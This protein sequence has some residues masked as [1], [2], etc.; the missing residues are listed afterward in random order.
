MIDN[1]LRLVLVQH[2]TWMYSHTHSVLGGF[3]DLLAMITCAVHEETTDDALTNV[4]VEIVL[5]DTQ[6]FVTHV[7]LDPLH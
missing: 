6:L 3:V 4:S 1:T 5:V 7:D 2:R